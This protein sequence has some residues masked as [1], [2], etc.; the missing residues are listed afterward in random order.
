MKTTKERFWEKVDKSGDC[1]K[2]IAHLLKGYGRFR[3]NNK[4]WSAHRVSWTLHYGEIPEG[5][6]VL[7]RCDNPG[8]VNPEHLFLGTRTDNM[9]DRD[10]KGRGSN[11][12]KYKTFCKR[13]HPLSGDNLYIVP[14]A[15]TRQCHKCKKIL[16]TRYYTKI[17]E[18]KE[19][20]IVAV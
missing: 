8:C 14:K 16:W 2:W 17:R 3:L 9:K 19:K 15:G 13:G 18:L 10:Q 5:M 6:C 12:N 4:T 7:H 1:W 20:A 11:G